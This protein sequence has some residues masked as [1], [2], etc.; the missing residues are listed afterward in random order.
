MRNQQAALL[1][2]DINNKEL[3][4]LQTWVPKTRNAVLF[5]GFFPYFSSFHEV[6]LSLFL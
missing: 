3:R 6:I 1:L 2:S 4:D 5:T